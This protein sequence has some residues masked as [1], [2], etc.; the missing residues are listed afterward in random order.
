MH[1]K[2]HPLIFLRPKE[3]TGRTKV[4]PATIYF[5]HQEHDIP[6]KLTVSCQI[7]Q[8]KHRAKMQ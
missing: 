4:Q 3:K 5:L 1:R 6:Y 2:V 8:L 7:Q